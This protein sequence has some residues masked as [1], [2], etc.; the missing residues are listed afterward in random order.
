MTAAF[1]ASAVI[2]INDDH[3]RHH[4]ARRSPPAISLEQAALIVVDER[5]IVTLRAPAFDGDE[6]NTKFKTAAVVPVE[7][8]LANDTSVIRSIYD[9]IRSQVSMRLSWRCSDT[10][11]RAVVCTHEPRA[12]R[13]GWRRHPFFASLVTHSRSHCFLPSFLP[14]CPPIADGG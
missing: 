11:W 3:R 6:D 7:D 4:R 9:D 12:L 2:I 1:G 14:A 13:L 8:T 5:T 10:L